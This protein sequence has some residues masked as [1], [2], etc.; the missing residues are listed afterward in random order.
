MRKIL[1]NNKGEIMPTFMSPVMWIIVIVAF[2]TFFTL[3]LQFQL[4]NRYN[5]VLDEL[6]DVYIR[7]PMEEEG[8]F[9]EHMRVAFENKL[10]EKQIDV[11]KVKITDVTRYPVDRGEPVE[12]VIESEYEI[13]ALAYI[14]G[15]IINRP[16]YVKKIGVSQMFFR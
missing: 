11:N 2:I 7:K 8:G 9:R 10:R 1:K 15:P 3:L 12:V 16:V 6:A 13:R 4:Y 5:N 14:G